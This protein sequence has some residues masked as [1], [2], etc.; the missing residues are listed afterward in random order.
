MSPEQQLIQQIEQI[1]TS[2]QLD[3]RALLQDYAEQ[4]AE[5]CRH[6]RERLLRC[7]DCLDRGRRSEAVYEAHQA[8]D[9][10]ELQGLFTS[11]MLK[12]WHNVCVDL[13]LA[14]FQLPDA[15]GIARLQRECEAETALQPLLRE[16]RRLVYSSDHLGCIDVLRRIRERD[17]ENPSW[18]DNLRPLEEEFLAGWLERAEHGLAT[19][20]LV[21]LREVFAELTHPQ[22]VVMPPSELMQRLRKALL[23][24][25]AVDLALESEQL[26]EALRTAMA[27]EDVPALESL[28]QKVEKIQEDEA[29]LHRPARWDDVVAES[30]ECARKIGERRERQA[31]FDQAL[32]SFMDLL[33]TESTDVIEL[34]HEYER[35]EKWD[36]PMPKGLAEQVSGVIRRKMSA[37]RRRAALITV[38]VCAVF[39]IVLGLG[40]WL[41]W[42]HERA[43]RHSELLA[44]AEQFERSGA[45]DELRQLMEDIRTS[46]PV[47]YSAPE[48]A[49]MRS[50]LEEQAQR[51]AQNQRRYD[52]AKATLEEIRQQGFRGEP[53]SIRRSLED[54][55]ATAA[56]DEQRAYLQRWQSE[57]AS[58]TAAREVQQDSQLQPVLDSLARRFDAIQHGERQ[59]I[60]SEVKALET[61]QAD[62]SQQLPASRV[63]L[64][65]RPLREAHARLNGNIAT[66]LD[67]ARRRLL[68]WQEQEER[69]RQAQEQLTARLAKLRRDVP[70]ALPNLDRYEK[71]L[72]EFVE[73]G[74]GAQETPDYRV[75]LSQFG[76]Y[77]QVLSLSNLRLDGALMNNE[78][79]R[80]V[81]ALLAPDSEAASS[82]W[83]MDLERLQ[84]MSRTNQ[85]LQ[86]GV[87]RLY[88]PRKG[89]MYVM[90]LRR[91]G[92][93][94]WKILYGERPFQS[95]L[96]NG[97]TQYWGQAY[98]AEDAE[99]RV[100][101]TSTTQLNAGTMI[102]SAD[103][104]VVLSRVKEDNYAEHVRLMRR[105]VAE[106]SRSED[107]VLLILDELERLRSHEFLD[108]VQ[109]LV[110]FKR[111]AGLL[112]EKCADEL[113]E[114]RTWL[115]EAS[116]I[117]TDV[118]WQRADHP[119]TLKVRQEIA[120]FWQSLPDFSRVRRRL[121]W[122]RRLLKAVLDARLTCAGSIQ[123]DERGGRMFVPCMSVSEVW[124]FVPSGSGSLP[125][126]RLLPVADGR[127]TP[128]AV[129]AVGS[130]GV[131]LYAP[132]RGHEL[133]PLLRQMQQEDGALFA[134]TMKPQALPQ[135]LP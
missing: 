36:M 67:E 47:L 13:E 7:L 134:E 1:L 68:K 78:T 106:A 52:M 91:H 127:L 109:G 3:N 112:A 2:G 70:A 26:L 94:D 34:R 24:E 103:F 35:L 18:R 108:P 135:V 133:L 31:D 83:R 76:A 84:R 8:P 45:Y 126:F 9:L 23:S 58:A 75:V 117:Q 11:A 125:C 89:I 128:E 132:L 123:P 63:A 85:E 32:S 107:A 98:W 80:Q 6:A 102:T 119:Q 30:H 14:M 118:P 122:S 87:M 65:S 37:R 77:R 39:L 55:T 16:Y 33:M 62:C 57:W 61:L 44:K 93:K 120:Q 22:R 20:D 10:L 64:A 51:Q 69:E 131:P 46:D 104:E 79:M 41:F 95:Q 111:F 105:L 59:T 53:D 113:P 19:M 27:D 12:K 66:R 100:T 29:F 88:S 92:T 81:D 115:K 48:L 5:L 21:N 50:R 25:R 60:A 17:P 99:T 121:L 28:W 42:R 110:I 73:K 15:E 116:A 130:Y 71:L 129:N 54:A 56:T 49:V 90:R 82:I 86:R 43:T 114:S 124:Q 4:F 96:E 40:A 72:Q 74:E 101:L 38:A 97:I